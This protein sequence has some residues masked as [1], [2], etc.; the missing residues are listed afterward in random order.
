[1]RKLIF[2]LVTFFIGFSVLAQTPNPPSNQTKSTSPK[3][4]STQLNLGPAGTSFG[5]MVSTNGAGLQFSQNLGKNKMFALRLGGLY[6]PYKLTNFENDFEG[7]T[8]VIN[9]DVKLGSLQALID[10]HPFKNAFK[11]TSG[12]AYLLTDVS[13]IATVKDSVQ[14]GDILL[15]PDEVGKIDVGMKVGPICP[16]LGIGF[17]RAIPKS[18]VSFNFEI[19]GYYISQPEVTFKATGMLEPSSANETIIKNNVKGLSWLP[20]VNFSLNFKISK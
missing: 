13:A 9:G 6:L 17:G 16:Y 19:G 2:T 10:F 3:T 7:T 4:D 20:I 15:S 18:K 12:V 5:L 8:L 11:I 14:Q 1:M